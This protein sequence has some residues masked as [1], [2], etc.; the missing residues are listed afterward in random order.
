MTSRIKLESIQGLTNSSTITANAAALVLKTSNNEK[1]R[2]DDTIQITGNTFI[3]G[4]LRAGSF[5]LP[6]DQ[7]IDKLTANTVHVAK[8][9]TANVSGTNILTTQGPI[10]TPKITANTV[11]ATAANF[12]TLQA[13]AIDFDGDLTVD[14]ITANTIVANGGVSIDNITID[15]TEIDLSS[16]ALTV[17]SA[18]SITLDCG[19]GELLFNNAG[20]GN[21]LKIQGDSSNVNLIS[22]VQDKDIRFKGNDGGST[23]T[24]LTLDMSDGGAATLNNGLTLSDGDLVVASGHGI[25]FSAKGNASGM[26][27]E[28]LDHYEEGSWTPSIGGNATYTNQQGIYTKIGRYVTAIFDV[29]INVLGTGSTTVLG[30][31]PFTVNSGVTPALGVH[32]GHISYYSGLALTVTSLDMYGISGT[33]NIYFTGHNVGASANIGNSLAV[34]QGSTRILGTVHYFA[35]G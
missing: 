5:T 20:N 7:T 27:S 14:G 35:E 19:D 16:G 3:T 32:S 11:N 12:T 30:G 17:D 31:L 13:D 21:L 25:D 29:T 26:S 28:L 15:G 9:L 18:G 22:I 10:T 4:T 1:L 2:I 6:G 8:K 24:A 33:T 34:W 23:I